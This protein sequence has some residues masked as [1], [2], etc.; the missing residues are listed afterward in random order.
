MTPDARILLALRQADRALT[1]PEL[2]ATVGLTAEELAFRIVGLTAAGYQIPLIPHQGYRLLAA[3]DRMIADDVVARLKIER[4]GV[5]IGREILVF[6]KTS[7][8]N[9]VV[10]RMAREG[11]AEGVVVFAETQTAGRGRLGRRWASADHEGLWFSILVRPEL[12][13]SDWSRLT[14]WVAVGV[15]RGLEAAVPEVRVAVKWPNDLYLNGQKAVGILIESA[16]DPKSGAGFAIVGIG[17]NV[18][19]LEFPPELAGKATSLRLNRPGGA[20]LD[21]QEVAVKVLA[22]LDEL[23]QELGSGFDRIVAEAERRSLLIARWIE[24]Q[25]PHGRVRG[26]AIGLER[27]GSLRIRT[28]DGAECTISGGE[29]SVAA[30]GPR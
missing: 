24:V 18:N 17:I 4:S 20:P 21:R 28:E 25:Y 29:V 16:T 13:I 6:Q 19:Q 1:V 7:S 2:A 23:Y 10:G 12:G 30:W 22:R 8:T 9:D 11:A 26:E 27:D 14:T 15:A 5:V 3:P